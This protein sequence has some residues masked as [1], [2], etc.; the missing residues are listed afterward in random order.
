MVN[1]T[2]DGVFFELI[3]IDEEGNETA[4]TLDVLSSSMGLVSYLT[5]PVQIAEGVTV[6]DIM[7]I[8]ALNPESTDFI[9]D[10][11][12]GGHTFTSFYEEMKN[13]IPQ[14]P[15]LSWMEI[16]HEIDPISEED[17]ELFSVAR[18]RGVGKDRE[19]FSIEFSPVS[20]YKKMEVK[21][22]ENYIVR[23]IDASEKETTLLSCTKSFSLFEVIHAVLFEMSYYGGPEE[24]TEVLG[25]VLESLGV[26]KIEAFKL[27]DK[28]DIENLKK[29]LQ[30]AIDKEDYEEAARIRDKINKLFSNE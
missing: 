18:M 30:N 24:R 7:N 1:I 9:F 8:L 5:F 14:D 13:E 22:N 3:E 28:P 11:S 23:K 21:L 17:M 2:K 10:S 15:T 27:S 4:K 20:S 12:L 6:E 25:E 16:A 26:D 19:L 29:E